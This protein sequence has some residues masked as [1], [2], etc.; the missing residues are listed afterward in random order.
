M[1][2]ERLRAKQERDRQVAEALAKFAAM[3]AEIK[4]GVNKKVEETTEKREAYLKAM[5]DRLREKSQRVEEEKPKTAKK[6]GTIPSPK[7]VT[8]AN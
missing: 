1:L 7:S 5:R 4:N 8:V 6:L 3:Q 2:L